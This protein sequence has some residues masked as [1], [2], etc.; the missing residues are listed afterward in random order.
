MF[1]RIV[2]SSGRLKKMKG[3]VLNAFFFKFHIDFCSKKDPE[4][5]RWNLWLK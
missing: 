4:I 2:R 3:I 1:I 5:R